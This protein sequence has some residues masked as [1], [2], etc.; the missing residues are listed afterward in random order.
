MKK[1][2]LAVLLTAAMVSTLFIGCGSSDSKE[3]SKDDSKSG[4]KDGKVT[5]TWQSYDSYDKYKK[6]VE[7]F[8]K[9]NPDIT[10]KFE[11]VSDFATKILTEAT[12][13]NL[14]D[15]INCNTGT[16]QLLADAGAIQKFDVD[17]LKADKDYNFDDFWDASKAYCTYDGDWYSLPIDGGNYGWVYNVDMFE[18]CDI[19]VPEEGFTWDEFEAACSKLLEN[20]DALGIEYPTIFNDLSSSIDMMYP[21]ITEAGGTYLNDDGTNNWN[22][23]E[24]VKAFKW[25]EGLVDKGYV[26]EIEKL[27]DGYDALITK[28]NAGQIA[29][30][31]AALWNSTYL[32]DDVNWKVM[33]APRSNDGKQ[34]EVLFLNGIAISN[35]CENYDAALKFV[36]YLTSEEGLAL[37]LEDNTSPQIAVRRSQADLSVSM[38]DEK[39]D[40]KLYNTG[41]EY[42]GYVDLTKT[43]SDQQTVIGQSFD[44]IWHNNADIQT[45][46]DQMKDQ[47]DG[48]LAE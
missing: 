43:F 25:V 15:L 7:A 45:T 6:I 12:A 39:H 3:A 21:W 46:L 23:K 33:N 20:K 32:Q 36:K 4:S 24:T 27:G 16:T 1:K 5:L 42:A 9:E 26:P 35:Q 41:L 40:M 14:P 29:M 22:S 47:L 8:E 11:E 17:E 18:K 19:T 44:E 37:Y 2:S 10:I 38:F 48:L 34:A 30:C 31:R 13:G 28:F